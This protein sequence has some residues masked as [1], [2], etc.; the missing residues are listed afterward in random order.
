MPVL[1][2]LSDTHRKSLVNMKGINNMEQ[3]VTS[4]AMPPKIT[5][6]PMG[7]G[8]AFVMLRKNIKKV[9][10]TMYG[11]NGEQTTEMYKYNEKQFYTKLSEE[12]VTKQFDSLYLTADV[13]EPSITEQIN[14]ISDVLN[15][16]LD[17]MAEL[18]SKGE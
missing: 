6:Q 2:G 10:E 12:E 9:T 7:D 15:D 14:N 17:R 4:S 13:P 16:V 3:V 5:Y 11:E 18:E 1:I 8:K